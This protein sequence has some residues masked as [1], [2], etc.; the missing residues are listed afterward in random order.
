ME[1][2]AMVKVVRKGD[3]D[4][5]QEEDEF[6]EAIPA[7]RPAL[8]R[9]T[10][11]GEVERPAVIE[12]DHA[13]QSVYLILGLVETIL[14]LRLLLKVLGASLASSFVQ[15]VYLVSYPLVRPFAG[16]FNL[17]F[18]VPTDR[19]ELATVFAM[20]LYALIGYL[21]IMLVRAIRGREV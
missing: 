21:G 8:Y 1:A 13:G 6:H 18:N 2:R 11:V 7:S 17:P 12:R 16:I 20:V 14:A 4:V 3:Y 10:Y 9:D 19:L 5:Y 15:A